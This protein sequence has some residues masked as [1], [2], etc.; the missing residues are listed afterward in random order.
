MNSWRIKYLNLNLDYIGISNI[1]K[2][3]R[4]S[5]I[6]LDRKINRKKEWSGK[7]RIGILKCSILT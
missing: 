2:I 5:G 3:L 7:M 1:D 6:K 4:C